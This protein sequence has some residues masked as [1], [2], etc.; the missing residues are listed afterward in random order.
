MKNI[1][2]VNFFF[3]ILFL[4][5]IFT[6]HFKKFIIITLITFF[7]EIGHILVALILNI[8][9]EK[10]VI[11]PFGLITVFNKKINTPIFNDLLLTIMGPFFQFLLFFVINDKDILKTNYSLLLFNL[12]P[13]IPLDGSKIC[14]LILEKILPIKLS[15]YLINIISF[16][17]LIFLFKYNLTIILIIII[18]TFNTY[19]F[20]KDKNIYF[21]KFLLERYL[22][23]YNFKIININ[24]ISK[25]RKYKK[26]IIN[27][28]FEKDF[29][30][31]KYF[32]N[33]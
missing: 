25:F 13:I 22:Y 14:H 10:I 16:L 15:Y 20:F 18:Y 2:K 31:E 24:K 5:S 29:L 11:V 28:Q 23:Q 8:K 7:H 17:S 33:C 6:G 26:H 1:L 19:K 27:N 9:I 4:V 32:K 30:K 3:Y 12:L 21:H